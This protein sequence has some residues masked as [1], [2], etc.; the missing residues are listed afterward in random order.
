MFARLSRTFRTYSV[1]CCSSDWRAKTENMAH[2][3]ATLK[4]G[5]KAS[6]LLCSPVSTTV[7]M[8]MHICTSVTYELRSPP[9]EEEHAITSIVVKPTASASTVAF[10]TDV[11]T[12]TA[13]A[14]PPPFELGSLF[15]DIGVMRPVTPKWCQIR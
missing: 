11:S 8:K 4:H 6:S 10:L 3:I 12:L 2:P 9:S 13:G 15:T 1:R 14:V 5:Q 7:S